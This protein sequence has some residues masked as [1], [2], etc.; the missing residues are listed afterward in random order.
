M[1]YLSRSRFVSSVSLMLKMT[2][3]CGLHS[4]LLLSS[5]A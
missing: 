1:T 2:C 5:W 3:L 4:H